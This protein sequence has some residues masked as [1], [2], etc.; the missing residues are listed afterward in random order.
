MKTKL[1]DVT[2]DELTQL[3]D[4]LG[5]AISKELP[6]N[7]G[8]ILY[9]GQQG[10]DAGGISNIPDKDILGVL[11]SKIEMLEILVYEQN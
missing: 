11:R 1:R 5:A 4:R 3:R 7:C 6:L 10:F 2:D 8:F 9:F